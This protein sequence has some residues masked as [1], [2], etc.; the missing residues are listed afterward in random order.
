MLTTAENLALDTALFQ[1]LENG[2]GTESMRIWQ[3]QTPVVV[4]G[5][6]GQPARDIDESACAADRIPILRR[7]SGGGAVLLG[8]GCI[9]Y[10]LALSLAERP[11]LRDVRSSYRLI[12]EAVIRALAVPGLAIRGLSD[13]AIAE[14]KVSGNAQRRGARA[15]LHHGAILYAADPGLFEKYLQPP[16]RQPDY[17]AGR[18][19]AAFLGNVPLSA[20]QIDDRLS[21]LPDLLIPPPS[22]KF[23]I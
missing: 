13:L 11:E 6:V 1:A 7:D 4:L 2:T 22:H 18:P 20:A 21:L 19:H 15:L 10:S 8:P 5:R 9:V 23:I 17:R 16:L 12:L 3:S 14:R